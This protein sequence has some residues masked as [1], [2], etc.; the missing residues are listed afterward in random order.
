M[1]KSYYRDFLIEIKPFIKLS[2]FCKLVD[3]NPSTL[4]LFMRS[5]DNSYMIS[6]EKLSELCELIL[7][8]VRNFA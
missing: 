4:S 2:F 6:S 3:L 7:S 1:S 8:T 5:P